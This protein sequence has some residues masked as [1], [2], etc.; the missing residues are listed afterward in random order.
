[1]NQ[2]LSRSFGIGLCT[3]IGIVA[4]V[5]SNRLPIGA[6]ALAIILGIL[7]G[8]SG[9]LHKRYESGI[10]YSEKQILA[11]AI[12]LMGVNLDYVV[13]R[14]LGVKSLLLI[15]SA[16]VATIAAALLL[17][18]VTNWN[19][20]LALL[21]GIGN[22][23]CGTSAIAASEGIIGADEEEVGLSVAIVNFLGVIGIFVLPILGTLL[24]DFT[25]LEVGI[26]IGNTLQAVGQ[27]T[28]A[29]FAV[30]DV[31]GQAAT[32]IKMGRILTL[33]P[34]LLVLVTAM[35]KRVSTAEADRSDAK[36]TKIPK[37]IIG[38]ILFSIVATLQLLPAT[39]I[40]VL[41]TIS[42]YALLIAMAGIGLRIT[43]D[44]VMTH[45]KMALA[46]GSVIF[47]WQLIYSSSFIYFL[48]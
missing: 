21:L 8:N 20:R 44:S 16:I 37:F 12:A 7:L 32:I 25:D 19:R 9:I 10:A 38:F 2:I 6:V 43:F 33:T 46:I 39:V 34:L 17:A 45:G 23:V 29:G 42:Q 14:E 13:L 1:M 35:A 4:S 48:F 28:A 27:V 36:R 22:G 40:D 31:S 26:L 18:K 47:L 11:V 24:L 15:V 30:S 41:D 3:A 5:L